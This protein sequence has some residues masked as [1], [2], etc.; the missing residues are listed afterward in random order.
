L[1]PSVVR[2]AGYNPFRHA[3]SAGAFK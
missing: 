3:R 2:G 1:I